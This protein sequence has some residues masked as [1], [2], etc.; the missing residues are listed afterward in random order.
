MHRQDGSRDQSRECADH[1]NFAV[2]E[3]NQLENAVNHGITQGDQSVN[4][5]AGNTAQK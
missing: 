3:I 1:V 2:G 5:A 4:T